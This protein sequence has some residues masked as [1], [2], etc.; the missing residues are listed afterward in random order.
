MALKIEHDA[1]GKVTGVVYADEA[2]KT[3]RQKARVVAVAGNSLESPRLLLNSASSL[4]PDGLANSSGQVGRNYMRHMTGSVYAA[5]DRPGSFQDWLEDA[6]CNKLVDRTR[7]PSG[8]LGLAQRVLSFTELNDFVSTIKPDT[9]PRQLAALAHALDVR[10]AFKGL[11]HL[12]S[13]ANRPVIL[14]GNHPTGGGNVFGMSLLLANHFSEYRILGNRHM[15][16][17]PSLSE[18]MIPV[19]P[20]CSGAAA[21]T[22]W[23]ALISGSRA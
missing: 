17:I 7:K 1:S 11:E 12:Q 19:D 21:N 2:G 6:V 5:F 15:K 10:F 20:F 22:I 14:F 13:V 18:T 16:F 3:Q 8:L 9:R 23:A 4:F